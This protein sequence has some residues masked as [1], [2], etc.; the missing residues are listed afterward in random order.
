MLI[1]AEQG[2]ARMGQFECSR[3][4]EKAASAP[5]YLDSATRK[6]LEDTRM[7]VEGRLHNS[8]VEQLLA[9]YDG[10]TPSEKQAFRQSLI[11]R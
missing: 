6:R 1:P 10:L 9:M 8:R 4:L 2:L 7:L 5:T 11:G 3:W